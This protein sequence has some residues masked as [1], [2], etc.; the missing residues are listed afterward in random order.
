LFRAKEE[1]RKQAI[2]AP[3]EEKLEAWVRLLQFVNEVKAGKNSSPSK[4]WPRE[5]GE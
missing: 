3:D 2:A 4:K 5:G 1:N